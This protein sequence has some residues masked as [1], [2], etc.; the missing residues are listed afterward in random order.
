MFIFI[1]DWSSTSTMIN[2]VFFL[3]IYIP[4]GF[5][6]SKLHGTCKQRRN[7]GENSNWSSTIVIC[8]RVRTLQRKY[9]ISMWRKKKW[10][11]KK[12]A[13]T[14]LTDRTEWERESE[15]K[16]PFAQLTL[17]T[18][19]QREEIYNKFIVLRRKPI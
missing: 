14:T 10:V 7:R 4:F 2:R 8:K 11:L 18:D 5:A 16:S 1:S 12:E 17:A 15:R 3:C 6:R 19:D 9:A 13:R